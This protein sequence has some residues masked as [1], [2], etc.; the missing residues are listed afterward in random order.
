NS[1][2]L[3]GMLFTEEGLSGL[4]ELSE[5]NPF[6]MTRFENLADF[7]KFEKI[8]KGQ[9]SG[10]IADMKA[11]IEAADFLDIDTDD[12]L[13][14]L[15]G[16]DEAQFFNLC[17]AL[18]AENS[19]F[20]LNMQRVY[21]EILHHAIRTKKFDFAKML[22]AAG[23]NVKVIDRFGITTLMNAVKSGH[24]K[25]VQLKS[26]HTKI[27]Q[28]LIAAGADVYARDLDGTTLL[29][30]AAGR[31]HTEIAQLLITAHVD[32]NAR[33]NGGSTAL[34][35]ATLNGHIE[36]AQLLIS[37]GADVYARYDYG[38]TLL[39]LAAGHGQTGTSQLLIASGADLNAKDIQGRTALMNAAW[40][41]QTGTALLLPVLMLMLE[42]LMAR[43]Y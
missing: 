21:P 9:L 8:L 43:H 28:L 13:K 25:I 38:R 27:V 14:G 12:Y 11:F 40:K 39:M 41:G 36:T 37:A 31:G 3:E 22:I 26:S 35:L 30:L 18:L 15:F 32:V 33:T 29:M 23:A 1:G 20:V 19:G 4:G 10:E 16:R 7:E 2:L 24:T 5:S 6:V 17:L 34:M 42:I